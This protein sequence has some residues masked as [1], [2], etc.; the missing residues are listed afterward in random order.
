[1]KRGSFKGKSR[2]NSIKSSNSRDV[3]PCES[4]DFISNYEHT[5]SNS[6]NQ[7]SPIRKTQNPALMLTSPSVDIIGSWPIQNS[8]IGILPSS[9]SSCDDTDGRLETGAKKK[10][11]RKVRAIITDIPEG[12]P[13]DGK[14]IV[15]SVMRKGRPPPSPLTLRQDSNSDAEFMDPT[16]SPIL[17]RRGSKWSKVKNAFL[18]YPASVPNSPSQHMEFFT[19]FGNHFFLL[20]NQKYIFFFLI[21]CCKTIFYFLNNI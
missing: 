1:M 14:T 19:E 7:Q 18:T 16:I 21:C 6:S 5:E 15:N 10:N 8:P 9:V 12:V 13:F 17:H 20:F 11:S 3:S 4:I 2:N